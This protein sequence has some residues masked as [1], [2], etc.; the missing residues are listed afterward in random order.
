MSEP[1]AILRVG[2]CC[3]VGLDVIQT[4]SAIRAGVTRKTETRLFDRELEPVVMGHLHE[5]LLPRL[6][7]WASGWAPSSLLEPRLLRL[8]GGPLRE[9]LSKQLT[10][11]VVPMFLA[12]PKPL[13]AQPS[14]VSPEF[15]SLLAAQA[16]VKIDAGASRLIQGGEASFFSAIAA[17]RDELLATGRAKFAIVGAVDSYLDRERIDALQD[18][19]RLRTRGPQDALTPGEAAAFAVLATASVCRRHSLVP[20]AW[21][22]ATGLSND[23]LASA[24][25]TALACPRNEAIR[26]VMA[27]LNGE[28]KSAKQ[29][30]VAL[31]RNREHFAEA[32]AIEHP[33][34][35]VGDCGAALAPLMLG[36]AALHLR[37][38]VAAGPALLWA[39]SDA[40]QH[41]ALV[42]Y[43]GA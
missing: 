39:S 36:I 24:C 26:L 40:G 22:T 35:H 32:L 20:L 41:G 2:M 21:I 12:V 11:A 31:L 8:A 7:A 34:E 14:F 33:A 5:Q 38:R 42:L 18:R 43:A 29:W 30:G 3:S 15:A 37:A 23:S 10:G 6:G 28:S 16:K 4:V 17:A 25:S 13:E 19:G 9:V 1:L 27:G